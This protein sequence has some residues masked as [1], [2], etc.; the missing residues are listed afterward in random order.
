MDKAI[1]LS[2]I[3][4]EMTKMHLQKLNATLKTFLL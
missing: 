1:L 2:L 3:I 4:V